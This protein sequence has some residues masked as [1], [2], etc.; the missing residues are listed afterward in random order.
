VATFSVKILL[1]V[2]TGRWLHCGIRPLLPFHTY[3]L[4]RGFVAALI[5]RLSPRVDCVARRIDTGQYLVFTQTQ[6]ID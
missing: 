6:N 4:N 5:P 2:F 1:A 3:L